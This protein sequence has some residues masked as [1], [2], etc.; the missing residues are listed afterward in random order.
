MSP[1]AVTIGDVTLSRSQLRRTPSCATATVIPMTTI[2]DRK[3]P[4]TE[5]TTKSATE[6]VFSRPNATQI[7]LARSASTND[8]DSD[9]ESETARF[10]PTS[11]SRRADMRNVPVCTAVPRR[12]PSAPN[13][14]PRM[15][16]AAGTRTSRPG[17]ASRV[18]V[19]EP[20]VSPAIRSPPELS[21]SA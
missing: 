16:M 5:I 20:R 7:A 13:T 2:D 12:L 3:P 17:S 9:I 18:P 19:I 10:W 14:L 15:P 4:I 11:V 6:M 1:A 21:R 8:T